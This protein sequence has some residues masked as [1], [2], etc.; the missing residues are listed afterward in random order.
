MRQC[1]EFFYLNKKLQ[2]KQEKQKEEEENRDGEVEQQT[3][4]SV[5]LF[6]L[7]CDL[8]FY[9]S[10][11]PRKNNKKNNRKVCLMSEE[12]GVFVSFCVTT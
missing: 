6:Y 9:C 2:D 12:C 8:I 4:V 7:V 11:F 5:L 10:P 3:S 1:V